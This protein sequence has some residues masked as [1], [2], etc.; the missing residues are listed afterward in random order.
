MKTQTRHVFFDLDHTL[1][2]YDT[3]AQS[4]IRE[5][6]A[7]FEPQIG[8]KMAFEEFFPIYHGYNQR[9]WEQYRDNEI[10]TYH[11]RYHRWRQAFADLGVGEGGWMQDMSEAFLDQCP[12]K[13][14]L[15]PNAMALLEAIAGRFP[16]HI[17]TNGFAPIQ[18]LKLSHSGLRPFFDVIVTPDTSGGSKKPDPRIFH[19]AL[20]EADCPA[21]SAWYIGDS[22]IED[23]QGGSAV[24]MDVIFY[25][26]KGRLNPDGYPEISDLLELLD[27]LGER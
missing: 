15:Q 21:E 12:R 20:S 18:D 16:L 11:L 14:H 3:N 24:G 13:P 23:M 9:L 8:R 1:W 7:D 5:L 6:L 2:D 26:P 17:I 27:H 25:N 10:D 4:T 22:Y 19:H